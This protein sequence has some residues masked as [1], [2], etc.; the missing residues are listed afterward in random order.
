MPAISTSHN[1]EFLEFFSNISIHLVFFVLNPSL[2]HTLSRFNRVDYITVTHTQT[3][4]HHSWPFFRCV[5]L[6]VNGNFFQWNAIFLISGDWMCNEWIRFESYCESQSIMNKKKIWNQHECIMPC[7]VFNAE[8]NET[9]TK[10]SK[11]NKQNIGYIIF[12]SSL[13]FYLSSTNLSKCIFRNVK[14]FKNTLSYTYTPTH[15]R[16]LRNP[17]RMTLITR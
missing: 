5:R 14:C 16:L 10:A 1:V 13:F 12:F 9:T 8:K 7:I 11:L 17:E 2:S 3:P 6:Y 15:T 4:T